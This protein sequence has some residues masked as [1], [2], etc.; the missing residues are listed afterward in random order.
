MLRALSRSCLRVILFPRKPCPLP[1]VEDVLDKVLAEFGINGS[2][3]LVMW[4]VRLSNILIRDTFIS[5]AIVEDYCV[6]TISM[7]T[8]RLRMAR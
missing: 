2:S 1:L 3:L 7:L 5:M 4:A 6:R 8:S